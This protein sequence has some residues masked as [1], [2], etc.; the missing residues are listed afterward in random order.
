MNF[1]KTSDFKDAIEAAAENLS[2]R[3]VLINENAGLILYH[4]VFR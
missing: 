1:H 2:I 3:P 4:N